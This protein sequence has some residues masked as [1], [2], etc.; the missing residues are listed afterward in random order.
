MLD[1]RLFLS[2]LGAGLASSRAASSE[3]EAAPLYLYFEETPRFWGSFLDYLLKFI[4]FKTTG[5]KLVRV[6][7]LEAS[8]IAIISFASL[9]RQSPQNFNFVLNLVE[10]PSLDFIARRSRGV[11]E[12]LT[13]LND[14]T[15]A[16]AV[17]DNRLLRFKQ[18]LSLKGN[19]S[20]TLRF[21]EV[22][23]HVLEPLLAAGEVDAI[24]GEGYHNLTG[25]KARG[26]P[27][28]DVFALNF[29]DEGLPLYGVGIAAKKSF[30]NEQSERLLG[31]TTQ[32]YQ[33]ILS[34]QRDLTPLIQAEMS[35]NNQLEALL[36][37]EE[38]SFY[39]RE[40]IF[41]PATKTKGFGV[42][43]RERFEK[44]LVTLE[45]AGKFTF[46]KIIN[47]SILTQLKL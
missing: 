41:T 29:Q 17:G 35:K 42:Y 2:L 43:E 46:D 25:L 5:I 27:A 21:E 16:Y 10:R 3:L 47:P 6:A 9:L 30:I 8:D 1:R 44:S 13:S 7:T 28:Q 39:L 24:L 4:S 23:R 34:L 11:E 22:G 38:L 20:E 14:K 45:L 18:L 26:V 19:K 32:F 40:N 15:I 31:F 33:E 37:Q 36:L 12:D